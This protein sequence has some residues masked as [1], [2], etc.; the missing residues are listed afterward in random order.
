MAILYKKNIY[1]PDKL[2][3]SQIIHAY[4]SEDGGE[5]GLTIL[6]YSHFC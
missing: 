5:V 3:Y 4:Y 1:K 2:L 6:G